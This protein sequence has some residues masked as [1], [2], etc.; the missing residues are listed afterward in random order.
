[1]KECRRTCEGPSAMVA[2]ATIIEWVDGDWMQPRREY[3]FPQR[4]AFGDAYTEQ[5]S[6]SLVPSS[7]AI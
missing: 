3:F 6:Q 1:M 4:L 7:S 2:V 5:D